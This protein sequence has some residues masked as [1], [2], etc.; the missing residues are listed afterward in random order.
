MVLNPE[1]YRLL[2][3]EFGKVKIVNDGLRRIEG[4]TATGYLVEERGEHY[5]VCCPLCGD[6]RFRLSICYRWLTKSLF[7]NN[8]NTTLAHCYNEGCPVT[9]PEFYQ[10][11]ID[12]MEL[13]EAGLLEL[14]DIVVPDTMVADAVQKLRLPTGLIPLK[15]LPYSHEAWKFLGTKYPQL[16]KDVFVKAAASFSGVVDPVVPSAYR[17]VIFPI[18]WGGEVVAWQGRAIDTDVSA[19]WFLPPGFRKVL[20]NGDNVSEIDTL[21]ITEG[22]TSCLA[23]HPQAVAIFGKELS[24]KLA[25]VIKSRWQSV[26]IATDPETFV[27]DN[28]PNQR[29]K[30][31]VDYIR[32]VLEPEVKVHLLKWPAVILEIARRHNSG[33]KIS[34]PDAADLG[35]V[36]MRKIVEESL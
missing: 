24:P 32:K 17:R 20:Y 25:T 30:I 31:A 5:S 12:K 13:L 10:P 36:F 7:S 33:S 29:G 9:E 18:T 34:V 4:R 16:P 6:D 15:S 22:I 28:R 2:T 23:T 11:L 27:P 14:D 21:V 19:R 3:H 1:L 35:P 26:L 8:R